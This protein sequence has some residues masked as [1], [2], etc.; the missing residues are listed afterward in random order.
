MLGITWEEHLSTEHLLK[1]VRD[2]LGSRL[3]PLS[4]LAVQRQ[5]K[6]VGHAVRMEEDHLIELRS[7]ITSYNH[8]YY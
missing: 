5:L 7:K 4:K 3:I 6:W 1:R 8:I 2:L